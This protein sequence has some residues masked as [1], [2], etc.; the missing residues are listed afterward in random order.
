[1]NWNKFREEFGEGKEDHFDDPYEYVRY[2]E[3]CG[4][5]AEARRL[6]KRLEKQE[7]ESD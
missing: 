6:R 7:E 5:K 3:R 4:D 1:M 2:L